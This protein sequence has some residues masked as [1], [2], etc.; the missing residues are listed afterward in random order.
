[1]KK[2]IC[3]SILFFHIIIFFT[4]WIC[5]LLYMYCNQWFVKISQKPGT[6]HISSSP[7]TLS[8]SFLSTFQN[9]TKRRYRKKELLTYRSL[10]PSNFLRIWHLTLRASTLTVG[11]RAALTVPV[12]IW[13][14]YKVVSLFPDATIPNGGV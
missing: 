2:I 1:M 3:I 8:S 10:K 14:T 7:S 6:S 5:Y 13:P 12:S 11:T 4:V 9:S